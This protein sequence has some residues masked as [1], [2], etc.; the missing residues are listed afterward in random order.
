MASFNASTPFEAPIAPDLEVRESR[1]HTLLSMIAHTHVE[2]KPRRL[3][4]KTASKA[5]W[6]GWEPEQHNARRLVV[7]TATKAGVW[8]P[9][10]NVRRLVV[11]TASKAGREPDQHNARRLTVNYGQ[12]R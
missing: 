8:K 7:K 9:N 3:A 12:S 2:P 6:D 5:G 10:H 1:V 11:K 4:V